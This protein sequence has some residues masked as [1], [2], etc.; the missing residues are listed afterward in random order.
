MCCVQ[1]RLQ[2][3]LA[4]TEGKDGVQRWEQGGFAGQSLEQLHK[5]SFV[6]QGA[7]HLEKKN[8][9]LNRGKLPSD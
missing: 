7:Q 2:P 1:P 3:T 4:C 6:L 9:L 5:P 8:Q